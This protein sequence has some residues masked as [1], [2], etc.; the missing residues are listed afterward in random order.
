MTGDVKEDWWWKMIDAA[1][2]DWLNIA[3]V[4]DD[5]VKDLARLTRDP[6]AVVDLSKLS[7]LYGTAGLLAAAAK[8]DID[9][10]SDTPP[11]TKPTNDNQ[12]SETG[13]QQAKSTADADD[14]PNGRSHQRIDEEGE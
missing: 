12:T 5:W 2:V 8:A 11:S 9:D 3:R 4:H 1:L 14:C 13:E 7:P 10:R 6:F